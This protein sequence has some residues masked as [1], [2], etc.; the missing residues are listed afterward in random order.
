MI[1]LIFNST[2]S[3]VPPV[4][5]D[6]Q[7]IPVQ[8]KGRDLLLFFD[9]MRI[10]QSGFALD[11][12][13]EPLLSLLDGRKSLTQIASFLGQDVTDGEILKFIRFLDEQKL[14][15][16]PYFN[17]YSNW[18]EDQFENSDIRQPALAESSY[19]SE[20]EKLHPFIEE[21]LIRTNGEQSIDQP[22]KALYA[23]HIDLR[24][25]AQQYAEAFSSLKKLKPKRVVLLAT[26]HY[27]GYY[28]EIYTGFPFI[29]SK[30]D[31][32]LPNR[33]LRTDREAINILSE[34]GK[35][36]GFTLKDRAHR[37]EHSIETHLLFAS[38]IWEHE[39]QIVPVLV[40]G[41]DELFYKTDGDLGEK[42]KHFS[43]KLRQIDSDDTFFLISGDLSHVGK[44]FGDTLPATQMR[45]DVEAFDKLF[46]ESAISGDE[47]MML[48]RMTEKYDPYRICGFPPLYTFIRA[49]PGLRGK[50]VNYH[51]W[52][53]K[54]RESAV[55]F[56]SILY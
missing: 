3:P 34:N 56:G 50:Q 29:G 21:M 43:I 53:E 2:S 44:K 45:S 9:P 30:K 12:T 5:R 8:D 16:S 7:I 46:I 42:I 11:S 41:I 39:F 33:T 52:D 22:S 23:P 20:P 24:I 28:P 14:L 17:N 54:E 35:N 31:Y 36:S 15:D 13:I 4:R 37:I 51:W 26:S 27:S 25:G 6:I 19:P 47:K 38:H 1:D 32:L 55:S 40:A 18:L 10:A 48:N 49:F